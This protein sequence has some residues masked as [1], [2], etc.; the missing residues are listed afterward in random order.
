MNKLSTGSFKQLLNL[1]C[2]IQQIPSPTFTEQ[3]KA[4]FVV[5]QFQ[6]DG[7]A[8]VHVDSAGNALGRL[9]GG[10]G[11]PVVISAHMD[12]V[13]PVTIKLSQRSEAGRVFGPAIGDNSLGVAALIMIPTLLREHEFAPPGDIWLAANTCEEG[14]GDLRGMR[15]VVDQFGETPRAYVVLEGMGLGQIYHRGLGVE[16]YR[17]TARTRGGHSWVDYGKPSAVHHLAAVVAHIVSLTLPRSPRTTLNVG[18]IQGGTSI[19]TIAAEA[20]MDL[21]LRSE[22]QVTLQAAVTAVRK[23]VNEAAKEGVGFDMEPIG[24]RPSGSIPRSHPLVQLAERCLQEVG[25]APRPEIASTDANIPLSR[26]L[27]AVCIGLTMGGGAHTT[28]EYIEL[29]PLRKGI[30][31]L[32]RLVTGVWDAV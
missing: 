14:L 17:I 20:H 13:H 26:G 11:K 31:Q 2:L 6:R 28:A 23:I 9:A 16:R 5:D 32:M 4:A 1:V 30:D 15:A 19:N 21:D 22:E 24:L 3:E 8:D 25:V 10:P 27:P 29:E 12:T 7:L 18:T